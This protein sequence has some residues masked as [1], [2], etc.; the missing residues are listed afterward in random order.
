M[1]KALPAGRAVRR[2]PMFGLFDADGWAWAT[3]KALFWLLVLIMALGYIPDRAYYFMVSRTIE[4]GILGWS[5]VNLCP[6][7]NG[8]EMPCPVPVGGVLPWQPSPAEAALPQPRSGGAAL[9]LGTHLLYAGGTDGT[10]PSATTY[11]VTI[12]RGSFGAW[13]EGPALPEARTDA[14]LAVLSGTGYLIGGIGPDG[15]P[16]NTVWAIGLDP[17]ADNTLTQWAEVAAEGE[18]PLTLPEPRAGASAVAVSDGIVVIG[19]RGDGNA[20]TDTVW[21]ATLDDDGVLGAFEPQ[22]SLQRPVAEAIAAFEG[23]FIWVYGG[24]DASGATASVQRGDYGAI[25]EPGASG[26]P[27][28]GH[29]APAADLPEGVTAWATDEGSNL[30]A[31]RTGA[32]GFAANGALYSI[33][34]SDGTTAQGDLYWALP[35]SEGNLPGGWRHLDPTDL[36]SGLV[37]AAPVV[38]GA[39]AILIGG[40]ENGAFITSSTRTSLAPAAPFFR[41]GIAGVVVP[42]L[43]IPG[44]IG[45][46][47]GY[48]AA[49]GVGTGN[50]VIL[51]IIGWAFNHRPEIAAWRER[52]RI[53]REA[54]APDAG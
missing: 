20:P 44:E 25:V 8:A 17:D 52:R 22:A 29:G 14:A 40:R 53:A 15:A 13:G 38:S 51:V 7:E 5:P 41:L 10:A 43:Q 9:Q 48:L 16:T 35:D 28:G 3:T 24:S 4:L 42:A 30:P 39:T 36:P 31:P 37:D 21:K 45:Q 6:P 18:E 49:A 19:G 1:A 50:F 27:S 32:S 33:G 2:R 46:Q 47:I 26:E 11:T 23:S 54:K 34:G 12:E